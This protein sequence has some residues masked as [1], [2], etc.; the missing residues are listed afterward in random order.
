MRRWIFI[1]VV[2]LVGSVSANGQTEVVID[3]SDPAN[4]ATGIPVG[5]V[6]I[7]IINMIPGKEYS[8]TT[9]VEPIIEA[10]VSIAAAKKATTTPPA[11][12]PITAHAL[13]S[14]ADCAALVLTAEKAVKDATTAKEL[15]GVIAGIRKEGSD[16]GC[17]NV[18]AVAD[19]ACQKELTTAK[20]AIAKAT[21][22]AEM[23]VATA[24]L[25]AIRS[26]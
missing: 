18:T 2:L 19:T 25:R 15:A 21:T 1:A 24:R 10:P 11:P 22:E 9:K 16:T 5:T 7:T 4:V 3:L 8:V 14:P 20:A 6:S 13:P 23:A 17:A 26:V 12:T